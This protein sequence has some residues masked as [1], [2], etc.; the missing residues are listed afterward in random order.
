VT[1]SRSGPLRKVS[2]KRREKLRAAGVF[3]TSTFAPKPAAK[4]V[5][6]GHRIA[7][8]VVAVVKARSGGWCEIAIEG[9]CTGAACQRHHRITQKAGG[10]HGA[11]ARR[12]D[13]ASGLLDLCFCCHDVVTNRPARAYT[14]GWSLK[15]KQDSA[16]EPVLYRGVLSYLGDDGAVV[17]FEKAG[18]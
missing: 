5:R 4:P 9:V 2:D 13:R 10:R 14:Y 15:E 18:A 12:S 1:L 8:D 3:L 6:S 7:V 17:D 16:M 11:A